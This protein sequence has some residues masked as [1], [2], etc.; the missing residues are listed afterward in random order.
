MTIKAIGTAMSAIII[1]SGVASAEA[2]NEKVSALMTLCAVNPNCSHGVPDAAGG[3]LF[4]I[5]ERTLV[6]HVRCQSD[7]SCMMVMPRGK[8]FVVTDIVAQLTPN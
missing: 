2:P 8:R 3:V 4:N 7:G 6:K 1:L 5:R